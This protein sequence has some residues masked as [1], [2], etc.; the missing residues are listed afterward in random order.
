MEDLEPLDWEA[1]TARGI[2]DLVRCLDTGAE[3][4]LSAER[5]LRATEL[6]FA[7]YESSRSRGRVTLPLQTEDSAFLSMLATGEIGP[8]PRCELGAVK[9]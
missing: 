2:A 4:A 3:P 8:E 7:I 1:A 5:A 6:A 9:E